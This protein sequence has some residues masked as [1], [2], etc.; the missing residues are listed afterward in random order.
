MTPLELLKL[1]ARD[2]AQMSKAQLQSALKGMQKYVNQKL[3]R[4]NKAGEHSRAADVLLDKGRI[5]AKMS[6]KAAMRQELQRAIRF[7]KSE[8]STITGARKSNKQTAEWLGLSPDTP[9]EEVKNIAKIFDQIR[10][11]YPNQLTD[12]N[13]R[14]RNTTKKIG[15]AIQKGA[16]P[17]QVRKMLQKEY[18]KL[19]RERVE[20]EKEI[21]AGLEDV[22]FNQ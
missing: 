15:R 21:D 18:E 20:A 2:I 1:G 3:Y 22:Y 13:N 19:E 17:A 7:G 4:L 14:Y 16:T 12:A 8:T 6:T 11:Q 9:Y 5:S 10:E